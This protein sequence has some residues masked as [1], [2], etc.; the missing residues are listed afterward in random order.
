[1]QVTLHADHIKDSPFSIEVS[2][3]PD[4]IDPAHVKAFGPGLEEANTAEPAIFTIQ[5][6]NGKG[7]NLTVGG[8][9]FVIQILDPQSKEVVAKVTDNHDGT[10]TVE[11]QPDEIGNHTV[12]V[13]LKSPLEGLLLPISGSEFTVPVIP[14]TDASK[15]LAFGPGLEEPYDTVPT[16]FT[17]QAKDKYGN[18]IPTGGDPFEISI[19]DPNE[20][21]I[22]ADITDNG[23]GTYV[24][25][26]EPVTHGAHKA[27]I[28]LRGKPV[29]KSPYTV[30]VRQGATE[31]SFVERFDFVIR[32]KTKTGEIKKVGGDHFD[33]TVN[34]KSSGDKVPE[35]DV[36]DNDDGSYLVSYG[37]PSYGTYDIHIK[38]NGK[39]IH[40]SPWTQNHFDE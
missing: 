13:A 20:Q 37:L 1:V 12:A 30:N 34:N 31:S 28:K 8:H 6:V 22:P 11:Y 40:G 39:N 35:V 38:I 25:K 2:R 29:G 16:E 27:L 24:A 19:L 21:E 9:P 23:N 7:E 3:N 15:S 10:F 32:S 18:D 17:I 36:K 33:V 5:A 26:Y 4:A 14:G